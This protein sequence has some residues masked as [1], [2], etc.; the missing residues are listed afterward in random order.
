[1]YAEVLNS[2]DYTQ[3]TGQQM[4]VLCDYCFIYQCFFLPRSFVDKCDNTVMCSSCWVEIIMGCCNAGRNF[5]TNLF[6]LYPAK[7][8]NMVSS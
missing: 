2:A 8:E 5:S 4:C 1:M 6:N 7:M 3:Q